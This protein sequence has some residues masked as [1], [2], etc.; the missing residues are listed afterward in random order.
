MS[1]LIDLS[2]RPH[3]YFWADKIGIQLSSHIKGARRK[4]LYDASVA[5][6]ETSD[7]DELLFKPTLNSDERD[8]IGKLHPSFMGGEYLPDRVRGEVEVARI[9][10]NSTTQDVICLYARLRKNGI[11]FRVVDEYEGDCLTEKTKSLRKTPM[12]LREITKFFLHAFPLFKVLEMNFG[13]RFQEDDFDRDDVRTFISDASSSFYAQFGELIYLNVDEW[14]ANKVA[15]T[16]TQE[17]K[18]EKKSDLEA[19]HNLRDTSD[20]LRSNRLNQEAET[21]KY[22]EGLKEKF[23]SIKE[24]PIDLWIKNSDWPK[25]TRKGPLGFPGLV[26]NSRRK[27]A[28]LQFTKNYFD[29]YNILPTGTHIID[30]KLLPLGDESFSDIPWN[31]NFAVNFPKE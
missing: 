3:S 10:L 26:E 8:L 31:F 4:A 25:S 1:K 16:N 15:I 17:T 20:L 2:Y 30:E 9:T 21:K 5:D 23:K 24:Q 7:F 14:I 11:Y 19:I 6:G 18:A 22:I 12:T 28:V 29:K 27:K 13:E